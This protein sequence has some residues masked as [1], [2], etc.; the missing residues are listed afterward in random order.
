MGQV[1]SMS[2]VRME[3]EC[4]G[5]MPREAGYIWRTGMACR[6]V[7][8]DESEKEHFQKIYKYI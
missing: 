1:Q 8:M 5:V 3:R 4:V 6:P 7:W 2:V